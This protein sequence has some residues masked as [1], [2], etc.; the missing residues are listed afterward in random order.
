MHRCVHTCIC[1][2]ACMHAH[3]HTHTQMHTSLY[4]LAVTSLQNAQYIP[5]KQERLNYTPDS[6]THKFQQA[7]PHQDM[8]PWNL[9]TA[10][11]IYD[12]NYLGNAT[13]KGYLLKVFVS[14][15]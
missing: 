7:T 9:R 5:K 11:L 8:I 4:T 13:P 10:R 6:T 2:Y 15:N 1:A 3:T 12:I 14:N